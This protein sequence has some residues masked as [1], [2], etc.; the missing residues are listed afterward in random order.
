[1]YF[2]FCMYE[3]ICCEEKKKERKVLCTVPIGESKVC[4]TLL[5]PAPAPIGS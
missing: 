5:V 1:M 4:P 3:I 2:L